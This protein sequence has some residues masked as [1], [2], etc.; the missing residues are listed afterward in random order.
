MRTRT[1]VLAGRGELVH[2][3]G[4]GERVVREG[5]LDANTVLV[6]GR[7]RFC[8]PF[9]HTETLPEQGLKFHGPG[10]GVDNHLPAKK[11]ADRLY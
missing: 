11:N 4:Y 2:H 8:R 1:G 3:R 6:D 5:L 7:R 9:A 10:F